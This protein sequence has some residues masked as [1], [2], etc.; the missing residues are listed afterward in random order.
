MRNSSLGLDYV[1]YATLRY[2]WHWTL[3]L[4]LFLLLYALC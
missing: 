2:Y 4:V 1:Q 3:G